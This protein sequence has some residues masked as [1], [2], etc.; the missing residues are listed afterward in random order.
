MTLGE[1]QGPAPQGPG[2]E[3]FPNVGR[4]G[5]FPAG[6]GPTTPSE[7]GGQAR[8][9]PETQDTRHPHGMRSG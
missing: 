8:E 9:Q 4:A 7:G 5:P 3:E 2:A 6:A 1:H